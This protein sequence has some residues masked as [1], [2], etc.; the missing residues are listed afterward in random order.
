[1]QSQKQRY[2]CKN[3]NENQ[4]ETDGRVKYSGAERKYALVMYLEDCG[5]RRIARIMSKIFGKHYRHQTIMNWIKKAGLKVLKENSKQEQMDVVEMDELY[6]YIKKGR[7][8]RVWTAVD[9]NK[10]RI[11]A[12][13]VGSGKASV[14]RKLI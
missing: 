4:A 1:M 2:R 7:K 5:F 12:F 11:T 13:E 3:C 10:M 9:R 6:T 14:L 8:T